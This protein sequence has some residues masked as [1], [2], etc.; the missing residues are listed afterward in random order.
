MQ[1][2]L[3]EQARIEMYAKTQEVPP[4]RNILKENVLDLLIVHGDLVT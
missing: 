3:A 1:R 4:I 2:Y